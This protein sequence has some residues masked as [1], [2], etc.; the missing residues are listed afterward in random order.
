MKTFFVRVTAFVAV[1]WLAGIAF[2]I[3]NMIGAATCSGP[4][5]LK[6]ALFVLLGVF[7]SALAGA[8]LAWCYQL[9]GDGDE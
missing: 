4:L 8:T 1:G 3:I 5:Q 9:P 6:H 2:G 7:V